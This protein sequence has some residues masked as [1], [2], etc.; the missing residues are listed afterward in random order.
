MAS[1][2]LCLLVF[3]IRE[4][5]NTISKLSRLSASRVAKASCAAS[6]SETSI[7]T[8]AWIAMRRSNSRSG[9]A[10]D[11]I[12]IFREMRLSLNRPPH[13][14]SGFLL[15]HA[16]WYGAPKMA[17]GI[18]L[19]CEFHRFQETCWLA[20]GRYDELALPHHLATADEG[21]DRP[22][23]NRLVIVWR[24][25]GTRR[26]PTIGD[27]LTAFQVDHRD[28]GV[29]AHRKPA[30]P[31]DAIDARRPGAG[32]IDEAA[33]REPP[34]V[35]VIEHNRDQCLHAGHAGMSLGVWLR[36]FLKRVRRV[37]GAAGVDHA[38][39]DATPDTVAMLGIT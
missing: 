19:N 16:N 15:D 23:G 31:G 18:G 29:V 12:S 5:K 32:E 25:A 17:T 38:R 1:S 21:A 35:D 24:P 39:G 33:E 10:S 11:T 36:L 8:E 3:G 22:T 26:D 9:A 14:G 34:R 27:R 7:G 2:T 13:C 37:I 30:L 6:I 4:S 20:S 28:V